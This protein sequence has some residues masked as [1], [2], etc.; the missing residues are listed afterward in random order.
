M[1]SLNPTAVY[2]E[3]PQTCDEEP[4]FAVHSP[5]APG[6]A[7]VSHSGI[8]SSGGVGS[9]RS[10]LAERRSGSLGRP[11][12]AM[13]LDAM[14]IRNSRDKEQPEALVHANFRGW[15]MTSLGAN[16]PLHRET[17]KVMTYNILCPRYATTD[18]YPHCAAWELSASYR[19]PN[20]INEIAGADPDIIAF[21]EI[22]AELCSSSDFGQVL[23]GDAMGYDHC[24]FPV[25][26][27]SGAPL[28]NQ[29]LDGVA[30]FYKRGRFSIEEQMP[31]RFNV[32]AE[33]EFKQGRISEEFRKKLCGTSHNVALTITLR[34][35]FCPMLYIVS[36]THTFYDQSKP[37]CQIWQLE[38]LLT[39]I[40]EIQSMWNAAD[41]QVSVILLGDLNSE[42]DKPP[43]SFVRHGT[44]EVMPPPRFYV[45]SE[46]SILTHPLSLGNAYEEYFQT[47]PLHVTHISRDFTGVCDH[48]F[49][50]SVTLACTAVGMLLDG[51][52]EVPC[53]FIPS[54]H[55]P[56][57]AML[58]PRSVV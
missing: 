18:K 19:C 53:Q 9:H 8:T 52:H 28:P 14:S 44:T 22:S 58:V 6:S 20:I 7:P 11:V 29:D 5:G 1:M 49:Y 43:M 57:A 37:E 56:L 35:A 41:D 54:D 10:S 50:D 25:T 36:T 4:T 23:C 46:D 30:I 45:T 3:P 51:R 33:V 15:H 13:G 2:S 27:R 39:Q 38:K 55:F 32:A 26:D 42:P 17:V 16:V 21:Q 48:I 24:F 34:D 31:L 40:G 47:H 12:L